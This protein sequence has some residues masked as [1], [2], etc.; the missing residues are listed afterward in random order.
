MAVPFTS[1]QFEDERLRRCAVDDS[2]HLV[3]GTVGSFVVAVQD[4]LI[5]LGWHKHLSTDEQSKLLAEMDAQLYGPVTARLVTIYK[6]KHVPRILQP[7]QTFPDDVVGKKT[8]SFLDDDM[9]PVNPKGQRPP[10][11]PSEL[12]IFMSGVQ[13][14]D[15]AGGP[16]PRDAEGHGFLMLPR[17]RAIAASRPTGRFLALGGAL[18]VSRQVLAINIALSFILSNRTNPA[19]KLIV[20]GFSAGGTNA[21][22]LTREI[23]SK[24]SVRGSAPKIIVDL[25]I[26]VDA[27]T[28]NNTIF[29]PKAFGGCV[30][31]NKNYFQD[32]VRPQMDGVGGSP[33][34]PL[35]DAEG[36]QG[37]VVNRLISA[38]EMMPM[39]PGEAHRKIESHTLNMAE[40]DIRNELAPVP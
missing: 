10:G 1:N 6:D 24:N 29:N 38:M 15:N 3:K 27:S 11:P 23:D 26:T 40:G 37:A 36:K 2:A 4:A 18:T 16:L 14:N 12:F 25:L 13:D 28:R 31:L 39:L 20:Y 9:T 22:N 32:A 35:A 17:M 7:W 8:I 34:T 5:Q 21:L 19:G 30:R 33:H